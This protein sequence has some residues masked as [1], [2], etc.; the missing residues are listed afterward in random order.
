VHC[1]NFSAP[2]KTAAAIMIA[3]EYPRFF[4]FEISHWW[5]RGLH[6]ILREVLRGID[7]DGVSHI[8]DAGCGTG[9]LMAQL[10]NESAAQ[11]FG[12]DLAAEAC[13][14]WEKRGITT[15][16]R[17]SINDI[18]LATNSIDVVFCINLFECDEVDPATAYQELWRIT[19]PGGHIILSMPAH[20]WLGNKAH[21]AAI[22]SSRRFTRKELAQITAA[23]PVIAERNTHIFPL[24]LP[25]IA[26]W[27]GVAALRQKFGATEARTDLSEVPFFINETLYGVTQVERWLF[28]L[29]NFPFG[30][31]LLC[32]LRK[33]V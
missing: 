32:V 20:H 29:M 30:S 9:G 24:F 14:F 12:F 19:K 15:G 1:A 16:V 26:V 4:K 18:P 11:V 21:D 10:Q 8:L 3:S 28:K 23:R 33:A 2:N 13:P 6:S 31:S 22:N 25:M 17:A 5:F 7:L 27:R